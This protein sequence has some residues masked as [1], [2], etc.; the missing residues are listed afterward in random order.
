M[1]AL[2]IQDNDGLWWCSGWFSGQILLQSWLYFAQKIGV[3]EFWRC[4]YV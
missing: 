4:P 2:L 1:T 3:D